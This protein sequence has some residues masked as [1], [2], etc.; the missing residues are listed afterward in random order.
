MPR[1]LFLRNFDWKPKPAVTQAYLA[2]SEYLVTTPCS[3]A[4]IDKGAA[5]PVV[6]RRRKV[7]VNER[8]SSD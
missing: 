2:D 4:A 1:V 3:R 6:L 5:V 7:E 8:R